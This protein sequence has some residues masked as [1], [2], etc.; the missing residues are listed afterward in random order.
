M[1]APQA[2]ARKWPRRTTANDHASHIDQHRAGP[3]MLEDESARRQRA[4]STATA[5]CASSTTAMLAMRD[6]LV[7]H[8]SADQ[9]Q[10]R[11]HLRLHVVLDQD[12]CGDHCTTAHAHA[13]PAG[14]RAGPIGHPTLAQQT[15]TD[16]GALAR[17]LC[18]KKDSFVKSCSPSAR[19]QSV[20]HPTS[21]PSGAVSTSPGCP[22]ACR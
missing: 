17:Q 13:V 4:L 5:S 16:R 3:S 12:A 22:A 20:L 7:H 1:L 6:D 2:Q 15:S 14:V 10:H 11:Q 18:R 9:L 8:R 21:T 19:Q